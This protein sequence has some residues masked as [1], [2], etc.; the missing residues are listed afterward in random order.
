MNNMGINSF[1]IKNK[2]NRGLII[3]GIWPKEIHYYY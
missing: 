3:Y 2:L 1:S